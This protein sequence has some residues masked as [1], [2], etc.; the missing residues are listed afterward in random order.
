MVVGVPF[1]DATAPDAGSAFVFD[2]ASAIPSTPVRALNTPSPAVESGFGYTVALAMPFLIVGAPNDDTFAVSGG[3]AFVYRLDGRSPTKPIFTL[4][5]PQPV[6]NG[7]FGVSVAISGSHA[8]IGSTGP[9]A[10]LYDLAGAQPDLPLFHFQNPSPRQFEEFGKGVAIYE[11]RIAIGDPSNLEMDGRRPRNEPH[12]YLYDLSRPAPTTPSATLKRPGPG[13]L[14]GFGETLAISGSRVVVGDNGAN[15]QSFDKGWGAFYVHDFNSAAPEVPILAVEAPTPANLA[16]A[17][18]VAM[19]GDRLLVGEPIIGQSFLYDL[20]SPKLAEPVR[21]FESP[22]RPASGDFGIGAI[23]GTRIVI[24][25]GSEN[26]GAYAAG[27]AY[28]YDLT[29]PTPSQPLVKLTNPRP[30]VGNSLGPVAVDGETIAIGSGG[31]DTVGRDQGA[32]YVFGPSPYSLWKVAEL[33]DPF[34]LDAGDADGDGASNFAE[35]GLL[36][37]PVVA[38]GAAFPAEMGNYADGARLRMFVPRDPARNDLTLEVQASGTLAEP[39]VTIARS[40]GGAPFYGPGYFAG[41][42]PTPGVKS[43]EVRDTVKTS[44]AARR[45]LRLR[46]RR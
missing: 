25:A 21:V 30:I 19:D 31:D 10:F 28:V 40:E 8:L 7:K 46:M 26:V 3:L 44:E 39:W 5:D 45:F 35:Y 15:F 4:R 27:A 11:T 36:R 18:S 43:V 29:S 33:A 34:A 13:S 32:V 14:K 41:D 2:L 12:V 23:S 37:S 22:R 9:G 20:A 38:E 6:A 42:G 16:F 1:D 24:V 17:S